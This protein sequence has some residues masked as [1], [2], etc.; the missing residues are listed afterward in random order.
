LV[1]KRGRNKRT[2]SENYKK[3][4]GEIRETKKEGEKPKK[5]GN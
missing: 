3:K 5:R 4:K 1:S 2:K